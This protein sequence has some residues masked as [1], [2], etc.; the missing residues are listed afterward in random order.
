MK[1]GVLSSDLNSKKNLKIERKSTFTD[2]IGEY[3]D[4]KV[5]GGD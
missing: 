2:P 1:L 3:L 4:Y 5:M